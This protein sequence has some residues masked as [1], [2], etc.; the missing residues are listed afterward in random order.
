MKTRVGE[1]NFEMPPV[2]EGGF[3]P[4]ELEKGLRSVRALVP[5]LAEMYVQGVSTRKVAAITERLFGTEVS[6]TRVVRILPNKET[7]LRLISEEWETGR[8]YLRI[9]DD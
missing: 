6:S 3:Y 9:D 8:V 1:I 5:V 4:G 7:C 2:R